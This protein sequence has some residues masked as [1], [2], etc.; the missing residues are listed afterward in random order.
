M[1]SRVP[2]P[3]SR[4]TNGRPTRSPAL[5][6]VRLASGW[7]GG[8]MNTSLSYQHTSTARFLLEIGDSTMPTSTE[9]SSTMCTMPSEFDTLSRM[10]MSGCLS[11][12]SPSRLGST[13]S[14]MV[15]LAPMM[16]MP[17]TSP[18]ISRTRFSI[19]RVKRDDLVGVLV[20]ALAGLGQADLVV[21]AVEQPGIEIL[22]ELADLERHGRLRHVQ[23][24]GRLGEA[25]QPCHRVEYLKSAIRHVSVHPRHYI[26]CPVRGIRRWSRSVLWAQ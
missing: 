16:T 3:S 7:F 10:L 22:L 25:Q 26:A 21:G 17:L 5:I 1:Y 6:E 19:S 8:Q 15:V 2:E 24:L 13:Y 4:H 23:R 14:A 20:D 11:L 12:N 9:L 18:V